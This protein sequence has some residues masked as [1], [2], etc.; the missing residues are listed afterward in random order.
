MLCLFNQ[1]SIYI[2]LC[3]VFPHR[4]GTRLLEEVLKR[5][6]DGPAK[7]EIKCCLIAKPTPSTLNFQ[8]RAKS[9]FSTPSAN[10]CQCVGHPSIPASVHQSPSGHLPVCLDHWKPFFACLDRST[11]YPC[12]AVLANPRTLASPQGTH[13]WA[14]VE[15]SQRLETHG[16]IPGR[17]RPT[18]RP[19]GG[20][21]RK[22]TNAP[23]RGAS[24]I[25]VKSEMNLVFSRFCWQN[26]MSNL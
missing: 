15:T 12:H 2:R 20:R 21:G 18:G 14:I 25:C 26:D 3:F 13:P 8:F 7:P 9:S 4:F 6:K 11:P 23:R 16:V 19:L 24:L 17:P 1:Q 22:E 10:D 5:Q